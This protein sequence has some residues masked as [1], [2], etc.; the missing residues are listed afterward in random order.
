MHRGPPEL[1]TSTLRERRRP[2]CLCWLELSCPPRPSTPPP[3]WREVPSCNRQS[4]RPDAAG[5]PV[6]YR[7]ST[8]RC[9]GRMMQWSN[10]EV[11]GLNRRRGRGCLP[12]LAFPPSLSTNTTNGHALC[13]AAVACVVARGGSTF[14]RASDQD[15]QIHAPANSGGATQMDNYEA[16][17]SCTV[18]DCRSPFSTGGGVA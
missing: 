10:D 18:D 9:G 16:D 4:L 12:R 2:S 17:F 8:R 1:S 7:C 15:V 11:V 3:R 13:G 6:G 5:Y 14:F